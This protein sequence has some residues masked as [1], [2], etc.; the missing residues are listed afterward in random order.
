MS[1]L[2]DCNWNDLVLCVIS[3][4]VERTKNAEKEVVEKF[5]FKIGHSLEVGRTNLESNCFLSDLRF[6]EMEHEPGQLNVEL[7]HMLRI[8]TNHGDNELPL[9][10]HKILHGCLPIFLIIN[11]RISEN[12]EKIVNFSLLGGCYE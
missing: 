8:L 3:P 12:L 1:L 10:W 9:R 7:C 11:N 2:Y 6:E 5:V 4:E